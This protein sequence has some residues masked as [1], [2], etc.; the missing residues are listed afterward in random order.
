MISKEK[1]SDDFGNIC[2]DFAAWNVEIEMNLPQKSLRKWGTFRSNWNKFTTTF[3]EHI[4]ELNISMPPINIP[5]PYASKEFLEEWIGWKEY[6]IEQH[7]LTTLSR[8]ER[9]DLRMLGAISNSEENAIKMLRYAM[10]KNSRWFFQLDEEIAI[11][12]ELKV[13]YKPV[14]SEH[15]KKMLMEGKK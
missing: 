10:L 2:R 9:N 7:D 11:S 15:L 13:Q 4:D 8:K 5:M 14:V 12:K 3:S 1:L 6:L